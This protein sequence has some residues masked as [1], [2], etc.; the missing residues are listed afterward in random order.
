[1][2]SHD[3]ILQYTL[4]LAALDRYLQLRMK[5]YNYADHFGGVFYLFIRGMAK[6]K[7]TGIYFHRPGNE[8]M[9]QLRT[10]LS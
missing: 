6:N 1:M 2:I 7:E 9:E 4:Y 3:Y 5:D 8:F 10:I